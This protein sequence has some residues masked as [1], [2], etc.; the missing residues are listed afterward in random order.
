MRPARPSPV[1][2]VRRC[3]REN[4]GLLSIYRAA[5][6]DDPWDRRSRGTAPISFDLKT[7]MRDK[8]HAMFRPLIL[9]CFLVFNAPAAFSWPTVFP[10]GVTVHDRG[11][12]EPGYVLFCP[13]E[14]GGE[15]DSGVVYLIDVVGAVVHQW[16]VPF[17]PLHGQLL[18][19]GN[20][21]VTGRH[22]KQEPDRPGVGKYQIGG[23][24]GW[25]VE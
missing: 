24:T 11:K 10:T 6:H 21:V 7:V 23:A 22:N 1:R 2:G 20:L 8:L 16:S 18:P 14:G 13:L 17:S 19:S 25:L 4:A 15:N 9:A 3:P 5:A 12:A